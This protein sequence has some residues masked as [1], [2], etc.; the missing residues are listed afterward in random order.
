MVSVSGIKL[1]LLTMSDTDMKLYV[2]D[3]RIPVGGSNLPTPIKSDRK[4]DHD[5]AAHHLEI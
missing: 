5:K 4:N 2:D 3:G 1:G